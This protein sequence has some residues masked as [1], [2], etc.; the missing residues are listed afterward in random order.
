[1]GT[2]TRVDM[3]LSRMLAATKM[4]CLDG[5]NIEQEFINMLTQVKTWNILGQRLELYN[6]LGAALAR[7]EQQ[8]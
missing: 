8:D 7:F 1:M 2:P 6:Q 5:G 4:A 3:E